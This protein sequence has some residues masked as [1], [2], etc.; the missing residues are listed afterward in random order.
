MFR[1]VGSPQV[2]EV[3][4]QEWLGS[5]FGTE[6][7]Y[8][9]LEL[10]HDHPGGHAV[11]ESFL[12]AVAARAKHNMTAGLKSNFP[13]VIMSMLPL[14]VLSWAISALFRFGYLVPSLV[15]SGL[16]LSLGFLCVVVATYA[17]LDSLERQ[18]L[19]SPPAIGQS[20]RVA[21]VRLPSALA[22]GVLSIVGVLGGLVLLIVPG[23]RLMCRWWMA[24]PVSILERRG[25]L[26]ALRRSGELTH[27]N[28]W[29]ILALIIAVWV[30]DWASNDLADLARETVKFK[31]PT[32]G[33]FFGWLGHV[34]SVFVS[35]AVM[36]AT[37]RE[38]VLREE[39]RGSDEPREHT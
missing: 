20:F 39:R 13:L 17:L 38:L 31:R 36:H 18:C 2:A 29:G 34:L 5:V 37:Y 19:G 32:L 8:R 25:V 3:P 21:F 33:F 22:T 15:Q 23:L 12:R 1:G 35:T 7:V 26:E 9:S 4:C 14:M 10:E 11:S 24:V 30:L 27:G 6:F 28:R 16:G